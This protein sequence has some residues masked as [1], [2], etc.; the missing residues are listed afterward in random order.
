M[1]STYNREFFKHLQNHHLSYFFI[2]ILFLMGLIFGAIIV[3]TMHFSQKQDLLFYF[4]QYISQID[5]A[6]ASSHELFKTA[7]LTH[8]QYLLIFFLLGLS[9]IGLP[10]I[11][12]MIFVKGTFIGFSVGFFVNQ[13]GIRGLLLSTAAIL[14]QNLIVIPVYLLAGAIAMIFSSQLLKRLLARR[15]SRFTFQPFVQY[16]L[17]FIGFCFLSAIAALIESYVT[18]YLIEQATNYI[19][20]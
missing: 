16:C 10:A 9:I 17:I 14:P 15:L 7:L 8:V 11:W 20:L 6:L 4:N 5:R 18:T 13:Y 3:I 2:C 1:R 19:T 12:I